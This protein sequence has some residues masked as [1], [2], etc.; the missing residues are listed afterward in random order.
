MDETGALIGGES[1]GGLTLRGHIMGKDG[2]FSATLLIEMLCVS[3]K[4]LHGLMDE[5]HA[6]FGSFKMVENDCR[7]D[8]RDK[9]RLMKLLFEDKQLP[10]FKQEVAEVS[11]RDGL[12]VYFKN[13]GWISARF[14]GTEPL[15][16]VFAEMSSEAEA[17]EVGQTMKQ[18]LNID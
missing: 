10:K 1:S 15:L 8:E 9:A 16:R 6:Q 5:I 4:S 13:G 2:I 12:K 18:F 11:Y 14:S 7:F 3:G 17:A